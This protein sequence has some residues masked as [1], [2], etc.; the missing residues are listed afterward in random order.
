[1]GGGARTRN[2]GAPLVG[3][4]GYGEGAGAWPLEDRGE[5]GRGAALCGVDGAAFVHVSGWAM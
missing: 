5:L 4:Q 3:M 1:M 2:T